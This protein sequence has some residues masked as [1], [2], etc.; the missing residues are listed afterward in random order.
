VGK[1]MLESEVSQSY[2]FSAG[3]KKITVGRERGINTPRFG[4]T[5]TIFKNPEPPGKIPEPQRSG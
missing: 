1:T 5:T 3:R 2:C 4:I